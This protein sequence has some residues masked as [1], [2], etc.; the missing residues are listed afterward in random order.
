MKAFKNFSSM[1]NHGE[2]LRGEHAKVL[3]KMPMWQRIVSAIVAFLLV[4]L[5][6]PAE[7]A[8]TIT[9]WAGENAQATQTTEEA[10]DPVADDPGGEVDPEVDPVP[11]PEP[12]PEV[13]PADD[14]Q[15]E[16]GEEATFE[17][18]ENA[19]FD[20]NAIYLDSNAPV[21]GVQESCGPFEWDFSAY[22]NNNRSFSTV[23]TEA[24]IQRYAYLDTNKQATLQFV[25]PFNSSSDKLDG[26]ASSATENGFVMNAYHRLKGST[27]KNTDGQIFSN[28]II[29]TP[30]TNLLSITISVAAI[31]TK[32]KDRLVR[33]DDEYYP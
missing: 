27:N 24:A 4:F 6:W 23:S 8:K 26:G 3:R 22:K 2:N 19:E 13:D 30:K 1:L 28:Y 31:S 14:P 21:N 11:D 7:S 9:A 16:A 18:S 32:I 33:D 12:E 29:F 15:E 10:A 25:S 17:D 20:E 5:L